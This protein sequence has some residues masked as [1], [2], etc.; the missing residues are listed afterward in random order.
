MAGHPDKYRNIIESFRNKKVLIAGDVMI[1]NYL[2]GRMDRISPESPVP[3]VDIE[4]DENRLGGAGNVALN[5]KLLGA[6]PVLCTVLGNDRHKETIQSLLSKR[7]LNENGIVYSEER[8]TT[9]KTRILSRNQQILRFDREVK[10]FL[11][12]KDEEKLLGVLKTQIGLK[13]DVIVL[14]D[15]NKGVLTENVI[16]FIINSANEK[17]I[18]IAVDPKKTHF[19]KYR[20]V[21][22]FKPN[23]Q[24]LKSGLNFESPVETDIDLHKLVHLLRNE[25]PHKIS[26]ITLSEKGLYISSGNDDFHIIP[27]KIRNVADV[28]GAGDTVISIASLCLAAKTGIYD[29]AYLSNLGGGI[30]CEEAGVMPITKEKLIEAVAV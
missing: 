24:E 25:I 11:S 26:L 21:T 23:L 6:E 28:S 9:V 16:E 4:N 8:A 17:N 15:Y 10:H 20:N 14:Q 7:Q 30:V 29:M 1:D 27:S 22:L 2:V 12:Q 3:I 18:P 19:T 13:P 5:M